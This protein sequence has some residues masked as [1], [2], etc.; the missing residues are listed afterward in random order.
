M[1]FGES[2]KTL[3]QS[4][5]KSQKELADAINV[6]YG[7][8]S[9]IVRDKAEFIPSRDFILKIVRALS[10]SEEER[11]ELLRE[12]GR[13]DKEIEEIAKKATDRP[14]LEK[15]FKS[16]PKLSEK[17]LDLI[18]KKVQEILNKRPKK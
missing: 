8:L 12:A 6:D 5:G 11:N 2:L 4:K 13:V 3:L 18:N 17:Q 1:T 14:K 15:L 10:C 9:R 7:Y 16:A